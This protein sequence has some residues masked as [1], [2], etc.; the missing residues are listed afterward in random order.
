VW[1]TVR[2]CLPQVTQ[3]QGHVVV[4]A[5]VYAFV[6]GVIL[7]PYAVAKAG[8]EQLG[9]AL[10]V[11]LQPHGASASVAYFGFIDTEMVRDGFKDPSAALMEESMPKWMLKRLP[12][13]AAGRAI[14]DGI[15]Q[16]KPRIIR[17]RWWTIHSVLRGIMNP[18][19][20]RFMESDKRVQEGVRF[21]DDENRITGDKLVA[22]AD[23]G[24][25]RANV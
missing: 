17:P 12:P 4:I 20:D 3:R 24:G 2:A 22:G 18:L 16:R 1:R 13:S 23:R 9:R 10:R 8:V 21:S 25:K 15:E 19:L 5:S 6:N 11:E 7:S 14:V